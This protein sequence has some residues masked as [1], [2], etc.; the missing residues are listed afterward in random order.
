[1]RH[2]E[3]ALLPSA[4]FSPSRTASY[5]AQKADHSPLKVAVALTL[6]LITILYFHCF[7]GPGAGQPTGY[8][9]QEVEEELL[10]PTDYL[11]RAHQI[12]KRV[13]LIDGHNDMPIHL[14]M[15]NHGQ[16]AGVNLTD[17][18]G[19]H[20]DITRI[21]QGRLGGQ[22]WSGFIPCRD[23]FTRYSDDV[24]FTLEQIDLIHRIVKTAPDTF[25]FARTAED[26]RRI[27]KHGRVASLIGLEGGHQIDNSLA[28]LRQYYDLGVRYLTLTHVC[29]TAWAD[30]CTGTPLHGG[31]TPFGHQVVLEMNR[32]GMMVDLSHVSHD[33][34][35]DTMAITKA[36]VLFSHS[37]AY[38]LCKIARNVPDDVL[39]RIPET[40]GVVM[41]NFYPRFVSCGANSTL[42]AVADH[43]A[44]V[45]KVA[46]VQHV[47][48]GSDF[49]GIEVVPEGLEDVSKYPDLI[50]ELLRRGFTDKEVEGIVGENLLRVME[51][52]EKAA[53][54]L[55]DMLPIEEKLPMDKTC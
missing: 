2:S 28:T 10:D 26:I 23:D 55:G 15:T 47:G 43:I 33:T 30:S 38:E 27:H 37:S 44:Y 1:M 42:G 17:M 41:I 16:L 13:P 14:Q 32:L 7:W 6:A 20:T 29:H 3:K 45:A 5:T 50:A 46:G 12:L 48:L 8:T 49:D 31:L 21:K 39:A 25:E 54:A 36:P 35:R 22:F 9:L 4:A 34:M 19:F 51:G 40:D 52:V 24:R 53:H 18:P 11:G